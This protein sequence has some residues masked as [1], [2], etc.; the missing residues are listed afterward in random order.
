MVHSH[1]LICNSFAGAILDV[2]LPLPLAPK[3]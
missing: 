1:A 2:P 3:L